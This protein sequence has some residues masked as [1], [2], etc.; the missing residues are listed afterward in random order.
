MEIIWKVINWEREGEE[1]DWGNGAGIKKHN[2]Q[3][4]NRQGEIKNSIGNGEAKE[5]TC[6]T[7]EYELR[8]GI[9]G[10]K[11]D[12][13]RRETKGEKLGQL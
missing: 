13:R 6:M 5:L 9:A 3:E 2:Q 12:T 8:E 7:H 11:G 1:E 10:R 4:Q